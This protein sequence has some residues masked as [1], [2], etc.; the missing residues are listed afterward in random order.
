[1][2]FKIWT[3]DQAEQ[4]KSSESPMEQQENSTSSLIGCQMDAREVPLYPPHSTTFILFSAC[5]DCGLAEWIK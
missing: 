4:D 2:L 3:Q 5:R 1:M